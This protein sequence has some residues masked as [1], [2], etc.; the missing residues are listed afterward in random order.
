MSIQ[1][2][3]HEERCTYK[4]FYFSPLEVAAEEKVGPLG[5][6]GRGGGGGLV[7]VVT[8]VTAKDEEKDERSEAWK[9]HAHKHGSRTSL[10]DCAHAEC[11]G[12]YP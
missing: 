4:A 5:E 9:A 6:G 2:L 3:R 10:R 1:S 11:S 12:V 8:R 7:P